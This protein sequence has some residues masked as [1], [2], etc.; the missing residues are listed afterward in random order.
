[1]RVLSAHT[2]P[3]SC[4]AFSRDGARLAEAANGAVRVWELA[5]GAVTHTLDVPGKFPTQVRV[6]FAPDGG[7]LAVAND[8][9]ELV[10]LATGTR[11]VLPS[12]PVLAPY[13]GVCFSLNGRYV[14][15]GGGHFSW[16]DAASRQ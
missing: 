8:R 2:K 7:S 9:V 14:A 12:R 13:N 4:L 5:S 6:A 10:D 1:M 3:I 15:A 16:W 11:A